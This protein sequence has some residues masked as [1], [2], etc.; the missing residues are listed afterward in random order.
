VIRKFPGQDM[1]GHYGQKE[2]EKKEQ[3]QEKMLR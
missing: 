2:E 1:A 3:G